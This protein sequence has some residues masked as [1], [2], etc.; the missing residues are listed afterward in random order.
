MRSTVKRVSKAARTAA[1]S[2][3]KRPDTAFTASSTLFT[4]KPLTPLSIT[5]GTDPDRKAITG[6][7]QAIGASLLFAALK[8]AASKM[9]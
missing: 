4:T 6:V 2:N 7:P 8:A 1:R 9:I 5:S 3:S